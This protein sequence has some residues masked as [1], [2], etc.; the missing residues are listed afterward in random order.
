MATDEKLKDQVAPPEDPLESLGI[1]RR[2]LAYVAPVIL[3]SRKMIYRA[4][5]CGKVSG[6]GACKFGGR[7][8]S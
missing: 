6:G 8:G 7:R 2:R 5:G 3:L 1:S 4:S